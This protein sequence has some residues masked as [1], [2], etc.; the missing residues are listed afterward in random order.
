M[1]DMKAQ[2]ALEPDGDDG[3]DFDVP[4]TVP[5]TEQPKEA[6]PEGALLVHP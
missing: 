2:A 6:V 5:Q 1:A 3:W 4:S